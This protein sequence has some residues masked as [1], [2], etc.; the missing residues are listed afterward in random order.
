MSRLKEY[1]I[2]QIISKDEKEIDLPHVKSTLEKI[3]HYEEEIRD[4]GLRIIAGIGITGLSIAPYAA[5]FTQPIDCSMEQFPTLLPFGIA[6][7]AY[8]LYKGIKDLIRDTE[9]L[10]DCLSKSRMRDY[11]ERT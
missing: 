4:D 8:L 10:D 9:S 5:A 7:G 6:Y 2:E 3:V 11:Y 1:V